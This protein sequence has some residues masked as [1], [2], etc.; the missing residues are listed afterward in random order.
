LAS[1]ATGAKESFNLT[2]S[3]PQ[4]LYPINA[5][6]IKEVRG[7]EKRVSL[8]SERDVRC[9]R[10]IEKNKHNPKRM[11]KPILAAMLVISLIEGS[12]YKL[13]NIAIR[14]Q[15]YRENRKIRVK[16]TIFC[17][18]SPILLPR[19]ERIAANTTDVIV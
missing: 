7:I 9:R 14:P 18:E 1:G 19:S 6:Q 3:P 5:S 11:R 12:K 10:R 2:S 15:P 17:D 8:E 4:A 13:L 16:L